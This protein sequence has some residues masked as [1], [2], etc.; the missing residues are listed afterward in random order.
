MRS[1]KTP[2]YPPI[3]YSHYF[4]DI[5]LN[6]ETLSFP[7]S[8]PVETVVEESEVTEKND[9]SLPNKVNFRRLKRRSWCENLNKGEEFSTIVGTGSRTVGKAYNNAGRSGR[10]EL[11][12]LTKFMSRRVIQDNLGLR[13]RGLFK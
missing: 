8:K 1:K 11:I 3:N 7:H 6:S 13:V 5:Y 4:S 2:S 12:P 9:F 10:R